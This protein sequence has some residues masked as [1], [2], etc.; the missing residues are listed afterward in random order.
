VSTPASAGD[1]EVPVDLGERRYRI[2]IGEDLLGRAGELIRPEVRRP[3]AV[4]VSDANLRRSG[5][6]QRLE[7]GLEAAGM[8]CRSFVVSP[9]E[10]SKDM[11]TLGGLLESILASGIERATP[12]IAFGGGVIGDLGGFAAAILLRGLDLIQVPTTLLAQVD[13]AIGGKTGINSR[14]GKNLIGSFHQPRLVLSDLAVL[15]SLPPRE[16]R[17]GYA[18]VIKYGLI[19]RPDFFAWLEDNGGRLLEGDAAARRHAVV[20]SARAKAAVV[21][22]DERESD[23]RALLNLGH[24]FAHALEAVTGYGGELLH[25][26]AVACGMVL[27]FALSVRLGLCPARDLERLRRHLR[28]VGLPDHRRQIRHAGFPAEAML[29]AMALDKKVADGRPRFVLARGIG[30]AFADATVDPGE[31]RALLD[32]DDP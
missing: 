26:E 14:H 6:L 30:Q 27:A 28:A 2:V 10:A 12:V 31:L 18:E 24:T 19:D 11:A 17:A 7:A 4:V 29:D 20:E 1:V 32:A 9:G 13:S 21:A 8:T 25:G 3:E 16:L 15:D 23:R 22:R 5:Q